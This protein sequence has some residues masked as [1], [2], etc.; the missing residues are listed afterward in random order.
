MGLLDGLFGSGN[1]TSILGALGQ[2][3]QKISDPLAWLPGGLGDKWVDIT[4]NKIPTMANKIGSK[5]MTPF[6]KVD[7]AINPVRQ[8]PIVDRLG[9]T[10]RDKPADAAGIAIGSIFA[11]PAVA[12]GLGSAGA[13]AG[14]SA[15][16]A[17]G[18]SAGATGAGFSAAP[19]FTSGGAAL[20][21]TGGMTG[22]W[23]AVM[24]GGGPVASVA[25]GF[26]SGGQ[27]TQNLSGMSSPTNWTQ[28]AGNFM[29]QQQQNY[30][31]QARQG[32]NGISDAMAETAARR[33]A[34]EMSL[35]QWNQQ[36]TVFQ[37]TAYRQQLAAQLRG[38]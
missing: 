7:E 9:D 37:P 11:A 31:G 2:K 1:H 35:A 13:G 21:S 38:R 23:G 20:G 14:S 36:N 27:M 15:G 19:G 3:G 17:L 8:I 18:G 5:V 28:L 12:G 26:T 30:A 4:S 33:R 6:D 25:P 10:I 24:G 16:G 32:N 22:G 29:G 34:Q